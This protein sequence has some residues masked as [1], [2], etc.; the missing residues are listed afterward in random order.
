MRVGLGDAWRAMRTP[1][2]PATLQVRSDRLRHQSAKR[3][4]PAPDGRSTAPQGWSAPSTTT[5][6]SSRI[7][8]LIAE[9]WRHNRGLQSR[10]GR[11]DARRSSPT[12]LEQK[13][14]G[15]EARRAYR[16]MVL[17]TSVPAPGDTGLYLPPDPARLAETPYFTF[18]PWGVERRR[19][20]T[21]RDACAQAARLEA[22]TSLTLDQAN[23]RLLAHPGRRAV[24]GGRGRAHGARRRGRDL[25]RRL[26]S[27]EHRVLGARAAS[28]AGPTSG[29]S[30][31]W[32]PT[33]AIAAGCK[34]CWRPGT[35]RL[36]RSVRAWRSGASSG[37]SAH[38][39]R[40]TAR[41]TRA[42]STPGTRRRTGRPS[43]PTPETSRAHDR[44]A[45]RV[46][47]LHAAATALTASSGSGRPRTPT[48]TPAPTSPVPAPNPS[49]RAHAGRRARATCLGWFPRRPPRP[50]RTRPRANTSPQMR[51]NRSGY[52]SSARS[53]L[54]C[55]IN[56]PHIDTEPITVTSRP[57]TAGSRS[58]PSTA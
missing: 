26:P 11:S 29:C 1:E 2:G 40:F 54:S 48:A 34:C 8:T 19:A 22:C 18:H 15:H 5:P 42:P 45:R 23:A 52:A 12:I 3:G 50:A 32:S 20:E 17:A 28:R 10:V 14:T 4:D 38:G 35:S 24:D 55:S 56:V 13:V 33:E 44:R 31:C 51:R 58:S 21:V 37:S 49:I 36:P 41:S 57:V 53:P 16:S 39:A 9:L 46:G 7:T 47:W 43:R 25:G 6:G 27:A 30:S